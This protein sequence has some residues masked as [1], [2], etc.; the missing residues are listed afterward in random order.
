MITNNIIYINIIHASYGI[1]I[2]K[3]HHL[4]INY[5]HRPEPIL[6][7]IISTLQTLE[8]NIHHEKDNIHPR[9]EN[10]KLK[11]LHLSPKDT[12][13]CLRCIQGLFKDFS[14]FKNKVC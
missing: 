11:T 5:I 12:G 9:K 14:D 7:T 8:L 4:V 2:Y 3:L 13:K 10:L 6:H 1:S